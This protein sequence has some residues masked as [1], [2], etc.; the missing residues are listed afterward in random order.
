MG[1]YGSPMTHPFS[2]RG[3]KTKY[4]CHVSSRKQIILCFA[5]YY[6]RNIYQARTN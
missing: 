1:T 6:F 5:K 3:M 4:F 2:L